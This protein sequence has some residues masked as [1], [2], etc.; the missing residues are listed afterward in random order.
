MRWDRSAISAYRRLRLRERL[1]LELRAAGCPLNPILNHVPIS[2]KVLDLGCG[3]G[4]FARMMA[5]QSAERYVLGIDPDPSK[6]NLACKG[7]PLINLAF[8]TRVPAVPHEGESFDCITVI[9]VLYLLPATEQRELLRSLVRRLNPA[10]RLVIKCMDTR[11]RSK[12]IWDHVQEF[13]AVKLVRMTAGAGICHIPIQE[14]IDVL[15][16]DYRMDVQLIPLDR[17][18]VHP[19][20]LVV[21]AL[22]SVPNGIIR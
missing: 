11:K 3:S 17:H 18:Y 20:V 8:E 14:L 1:Y 22:S 7:T 4:L 19:H 6:V 12:L 21:G 2:G 13:V 9:D 5:V 15:A 16:S 10:G